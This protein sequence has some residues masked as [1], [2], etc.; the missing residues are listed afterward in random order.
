MSVDAHLAQLE[1]KHK[2]LD[3][4]LETERAHPQVDEVRVANL[5]RRKLKI[6]D[7]ITALRQTRKPSVN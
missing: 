7:E 6:K 1:R 4:E 2:S 5:K 3:L